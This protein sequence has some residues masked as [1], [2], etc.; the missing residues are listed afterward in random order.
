MT[1][2]SNSS[3]FEEHIALIYNS[4]MDQYMPEYFKSFQYTPWVFSLLGSVVI[5]LSGIFPLLIIP[6]DE[7]M[8]KQGYKDPA[9]SKLLRVLLSFAVGGLLGDVFLHLLP[10]A[11]EGDSQDP[12]SHPSLR[13]GLWVLSGIL[14]FT[15][16]EKIFSG[17]ASADDENP[18]PKC[19]EI[20][21]CLLRR[22]GG[23]LPDGETSDSCGGACDIEDV[24][25]VC[26]LRE[27][28][29]KSKE[30]K[31]QPK[32]VAG[33]LNLLANSIDN[34]THGLA[35][36]GSFLVSFRHGVLATFAILLH[37]IPHEVG[38]FAILL[39]S[40]FSRWD[41]ARAQLLTAGAG[42]LGALVAI[43]GSGVTS[44]MEARTSWIMPFTAGGFLHIAL[45]TVLP[46]LLKEE[47]RKESIKQLLALVFGIALMA[48]MTMLF[49][50]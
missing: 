7:K 42:L 5:G 30:K 37:E 34:F 44:A 29:Q 41:A 23:K 21:N 15:I 24:D 20:A 48:V 16:V 28:E 33:Y 17:Y 2:I 14:I 46:D 19:V 49:E 40:G 12:S 32:K 45:V 13:S 26:F 50:H 6:T 27:R 36:A 3:F 11:W 25:K 47:E 39:R 43:G 1:T 35:V 18:Q 9:E 10:E 38:D 8:A 22:H 31:E 4:L